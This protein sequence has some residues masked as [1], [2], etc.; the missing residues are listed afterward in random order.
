MLRHHL[1]TAIRNLKRYKLFTFINV[2]GLSLGIAIFLSLMAYVEYHFG[3]DKFYERGSKIYRL[4]Y[5]E[6][7]SGQPV[8]QSSRSH[9]RAALLIHEYAPQAEAVTRIYHEKAYIFNEDVRLVDQDM[10]FADSSFFK[11]F[12]VKIISGSAETGLV[13]PNSV[14]ISQSQ[15]RA[16]FGNVD[17]IGK[18]IFFNEN[19]PTT[20]TGIFEDIP[21]TTSVDYNFLLSWSTIYFYGWGPREGDFDSPGNFTF[22]RLKDKVVDIEG[23]NDDLTKN[24][25]RAHHYFKKSWSHRSV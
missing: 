1:L 22:V 4:N 13:A 17:P 5:F 7:Q 18:T 3:F 2:F 9:S 20:I 25:K 10:L 21:K 12:P 8:L 15:A 14:M 24:G 23:V 11:V 16:Y 6:Y 19:L